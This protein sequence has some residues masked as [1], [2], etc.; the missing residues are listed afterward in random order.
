MP[1]FEKLIGNEKIKQELTETMENQTISHS[2]MFVG[3]SG[4]GK[5]LFAREFAKGLLGDF[6]KDILN[7]EDYKEI[8]PLEGKKIISVD[9][10]RE[11]IKEANELPTESEKRVFVIDE[12]DK[13]NTE[14]QNSILKTL[15]EPPEYVV[16]IL[17]VTNES[18]MLETIKSRCNIIKFDTLKELEIEK[19]LI[20]ENLLD[21]SRKDVEIKLLNG[22]LENVNNL[23]SMLENYDYLKV[24]VSYIKKK[25]IIQALNNGLLLYESKDDIINLLDLLNIVFLEERLTKCVFVVESTKT[26][27]LQNNNYNMCIDNLIMKSIDSI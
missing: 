12:A 21:K 9:Q 27:I 13:M 6:N 8:G 15:E 20:K 2:Y 14:A 19:Y 23:D 1:Y 10:I 25:D 22:S 5:R 17:I 24:L 16:I 4:I 11:I 26:K 3:K 18:K 7:Y